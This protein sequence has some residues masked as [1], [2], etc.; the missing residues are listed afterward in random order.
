MHEISKI[1]KIRC[2]DRKIKVIKKV[3]NETKKWGNVLI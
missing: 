2:K 1:R 3:K